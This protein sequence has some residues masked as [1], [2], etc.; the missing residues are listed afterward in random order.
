MSS[1][2]AFLTYTFR[3]RAKNICGAQRLSW[4]NI[5]KLK[6]G[7]EDFF[8]SFFC[9]N[10]IFS[11]KNR[12]CY[13]AHQTARYIDKSIDI[14]DTFKFAHPNQV[15][16][17]LEKYCDDHYRLKL[18]DLYCEYAGKYFRYWNTSIKLPFLYFYEP[19]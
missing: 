13:V 16:G 7:V 10:F 3:E 1:S 4:A 17:A 12:V 19:I 18:W 8:A 2:S 6:N 14:R 5:P 9:Q 15:I 11:P